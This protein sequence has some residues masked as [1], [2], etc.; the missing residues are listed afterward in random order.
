MPLT[1]VF[2]T[3]KEL[4]QFMLTKDKMGAVKWG[5]DG[6]WLFTNH[7]VR[8]EGTMFPCPNCEF[9]AAHKTW[10]TTRYIKAKDAFMNK[11]ACV[12]CFEKSDNGYEAGYFT[13]AN[14]A[15]FDGIHAKLNDGGVWDSDHATMF[16]HG[17]L[18]Y[19]TLPNYSYMKMIVSSE[20]M[21]KVV[22]M[23]DATGTMSDRELFEA[24]PKNH[25]FGRHCKSDCRQMSDC[26]YCEECGKHEHEGCECEE[27]EEEDNNDNDYCPI[28]NVLTNTKNCAMSKSCCMCLEITFC[29]DCVKECEPNLSG[30]CSHDWE[31][32]HIC[33]KCQ[34][35]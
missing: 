18:W 1:I 6:K 28:C 11:D 21:K 12:E 16:K 23:G 10:D 4:N 34:E 8:T 3:E 33:G 26:H 29:D 31:T 27:E 19:A 5:E 30:D 9:C 14:E 13:T 15:F 24:I 22:L 32:H 17:A 25:P 7:K 20:W 35:E 2:N